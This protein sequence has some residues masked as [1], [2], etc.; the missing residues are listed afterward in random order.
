MADNMKMLNFKMGNYAGLKD[1]AIKAGTV[2]VTKDEKAMYVDIDDSTRIRL[3]QTVVIDTMEAFEGLKPPYSHEA[4]YYVK[5]A[6]ALLRNNGTETNPNWVQ[7]NSVADIQSQVDAL[8]VLV[9]GAKKEDGSREGGLVSDVSGLKTAS[10]S[11]GNDIAALKDVVDGYT[12]KGSIKAAVDAAKKA[13]DD[14]QGEIDALE[15]VVGTKT[16]DHGT[17]YGEI[18]SLKNA[19]AQHEK[20]AADTYATQTA[21]NA[22]SGDVEKLNAAVSGYE[23]EG[24]IKAAVD[25]AAAKGQAGIDAAEAA[26]GEIDALEAV[27]GSKSDDSTKDT[28]YGAIAKV[29]ADAAAAYALQSELDKTNTAVSNAQGKIDDLEAVV[30]AQGSNGTVYAEIE[31]LKQA[32]TNINNAI[33]TATTAGTIRYEI[34]QLQ[35]KDVA[36]D[37][38]L[39]DYKE[40]VADTYATQQSLSQTNTNVTNVTNLVG[41]VNDAADANTAFGKI[42]ANKAAIEANDADI[43]QL[44]KDVAALTGGDTSV[45]KLIENAIN[46]QA[47]IQAGID[48]AQDK[49]IGEHTTAISNINGE[50]DGIDAEIIKLKAED[51]ELAGLIGDNADAIQDVADDLSAFE[52]TVAETYATKAALKEVDDVVKGHTTTI[53]EHGQAIEANAEAI[54]ALQNIVKDGGTLEVRVDAVEDKADKNAEDILALQNIVKDGGS[55]EVRVDKCE[56]DI[57]GLTTTVNGHT[58]TIAT[59]E[60]KED[61][62][63]KLQDAKDYADEVAGTAED[64]AKA[65]ADSLLQANDAMLFKG[66]VDSNNGLPT[67]GVE[68]GWTYKVAEAGTYNGVE[69]RIGDL[70]IAS[71]KEENGVLTSITW[72]HIESGYVDEYVPTL[73]EDGGVIKLT[74]A[75]ST[76]AGDLGQIVLTGGDSVQVSMSATQPNGVKG[77]LV[78]ATIALTWGEF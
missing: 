72:N 41:T 63:K 6:N 29:A 7:I 40:V 27:V 67:A 39:S 24:A 22:I 15:L 13:A 46:A 21:V 76:T 37:Q 3:G 62:S 25:A 4:F 75:V 42:A 5:D 53:G 49:T 54:E 16:A 45:S 74:S 18:D 2:Y 14:A 52:G 47:Q 1:V 19:L 51:E 10:T 34:D 43:E 17:V 12:A 26:Q 9:N 65:Y 44:Q 70:F 31:A 61:A 36:Q 69:A 33:G 77:E 55:L 73:T 71:G 68:S 38:A 64:N 57:A 50:I 35:K 20:D 60:T 56:T 59:L 32:D 11:H 28:V 78:T 23:G 8:D 66:V 30:G 48:A 58:T